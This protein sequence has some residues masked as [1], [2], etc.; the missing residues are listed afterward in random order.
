MVPEPVVNCPDF[1]GIHVEETGSSSC[2]VATHPQRNDGVSKMNMP[3][4]DRLLSLE[5][6][7]RLLGI[8]N[9]KLFELLKTGEISARK[10]GA[11]TVVPESEIVR[12]Q[13]QL[14]QVR[15]Q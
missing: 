1:F 4:A 11:R 5:E 7:R 15:C 6:T 3:T 14:P 9:T 2:F 13:Q 8:G 12:F 10:L